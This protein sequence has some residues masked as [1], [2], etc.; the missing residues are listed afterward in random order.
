MYS[1]IA[2][3]A[4]FRLQTCPG[5]CHTKLRSAVCIATIAMAIFPK[6]KVLKACDLVMND[7]CLTCT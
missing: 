7:T 1:T 6:Q 2:I 5:F 3:L 4:I